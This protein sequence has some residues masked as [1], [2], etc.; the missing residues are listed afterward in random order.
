MGGYFAELHRRPDHHKKRFAFL[1]SLTIT[2]F[3]FSIWSLAVF[4]VSDN[5]IVVSNEPV[6]I[7]ETENETGPFKAFYLNLAS[8]FSAI[9]TSFKELKNGVE[10]INIESGYTEMRDNS[11]EIYGQ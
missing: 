8:S 5:K 9:G 11:L 4:G 6:I 3:I 1:T 2:L 7:S 10:T